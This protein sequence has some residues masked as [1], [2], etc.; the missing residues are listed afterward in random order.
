MTFR[1]RAA[2]REMK[3]NPVP[4]DDNKIRLAYI[5][6][7][8][9]SGSTLLAMLLNAHPEICTVGELK[10][11]S[12]GD[13]DRYR[14]SC[15]RRIRECPFWDRIA[16]EMAGRGL[17]FDIADSG[18][19]FRSGASPYVLKLLQPLYRGGVFESVREILL[20]MSPQWRAQLPKIQSMNSALMSAVLSQT[21]KKVIVDSSK[22]GIRLKFLMKNPKLDIKIIRLIR[23]GR[24]VSLTYMD[25]AN[26]ADS[27]NVA[28]RGGG[29]GGDRRLEKHSM[30]LSAREWRRSNEEAA[31]LLNRVDRS[32]WIAIHYEEL[33]REPKR[34]LEEVFSFLDVSPDGFQQDFRSV[35]HHIIGNGMRLDSTNEIEVDERW[36]RQLT[37]A[38]L[39]A[40]DRAAGRTNRRLG[41]A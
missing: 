17:E 2:I 40:F 11:T 16:K 24:A 8:S 3:R 35:E 26:F 38:E 31:A 34:K 28:L 6:S 19:D 13:V 4:P 22:I 25:P 7:A 29:S 10:V 1:G 27:R 21:K 37:A 5:L 30:D 15:R 18:T 41:Y 14:C 36:K 9:H 32:K 20:L 23:D 33:C 12:L 39:V